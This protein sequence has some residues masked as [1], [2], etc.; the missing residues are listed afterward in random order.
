MNVTNLPPLP[1]VLL[2]AHRADQSALELARNGVQRHGWHSAYGAMLI[3]VCVD[4]A[5]VN[6]LR[7]TAMAQYARPRSMRWVQ[8]AD[9]GA[10]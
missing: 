6:G 5:Y 8:E 1:E 3:A 4:A 7:V 10:L 2:G 9:R